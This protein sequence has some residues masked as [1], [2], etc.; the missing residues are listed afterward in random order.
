MKKILV[1][2]LMALLITITLTPVSN[3][4]ASQQAWDYSNDM[5]SNRVGFG[6][7]NVN[8]KTYLFGG[9]NNSA[10]NKVEEYN[11]NTNTWT[12]K[13]NMPTAKGVFG[14]AVVNDKVYIIGGF[15]GNPAYFNSGSALSSVEEYD[16]ASD[17]WKSK[18]PIP[19]PL[20]W[21]SAA[22]YNGK[23]YVFGGARNQTT[24][25]T[26]IVYVYDPLTDTWSTKNNMPVSLQGFA[27]IVVNNKIYLLGGYNESTIIQKSLWEYDPLRDSWV[28]KTDMSSARASHSMIYSNGIIYAIGGGL[29]AGVATNLV[30]QY[31]VATDTWVTGPSLNQARWGFGASI[32]DGQIHVFGGGVTS[33]YTKTVEVLTVHEAP[34]TNGRAILV[35]TLDTGLEKEYDLAMSEVNAFIDWY[36][37]K[38]AGVGRASYAIDKHENNRGP[39]KSRKDY[40]IFD[41]ILTYEVNE[42]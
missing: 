10:L 13:T 34:T 33:G 30:E 25:A 20:F 5:P 22:V 37:N 16:P 32:N 38:H 41:K 29:V 35:V 19:D 3:V 12:T 21:T 39:Y 24:P 4:F 28:Q 40:L 15:T 9:Y 14:T 23:I 18:S 42:Y 17:S 26:N 27:S 11:P 31:N 1:W 7:A 2:F 8:G 36:E 6:T